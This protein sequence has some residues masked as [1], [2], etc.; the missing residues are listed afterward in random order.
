MRVWCVKCRLFNVV[1]GPHREMAVDVPESFIARNKTPPRYP[2][3]RPPQVGGPP[4]PHKPTK[5][6]A[7]PTPAK[8]TL[9]RQTALDDEEGELKPHKPAKTFEPKPHED[10]DS[11]MDVEVLITDGDMIKVKD[12]LNFSNSGP[13]SGSGSSSSFG[14]KKSSRGSGSQGTSNATQSIRSVSSSAKDKSVLS[15]D[16]PIS[17]GKSSVAYDVNED[18]MVKLYIS[19]DK[20]PFS[21][22]LFGESVA[23][24]ALNESVMI[25]IVPGYPKGED[26]PLPA[27]SPLSSS[28]QRAP[29]GLQVD[30]GCRYGHREMAVDVPD[31]FVQIVKSTPKYPGSE[32]KPILAPQVT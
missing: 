23:F 2:P 13:T 31:G 22:I 19:D 17:I 18:N 3:P 5:P 30:A 26:S 12:D 20:N 11:K 10:K 29:A 9:I 28:S 25:P 21:K 16:S 15:E 8:L 1:A 14:S 6:S 27:Y 4:T 32:K 7:K 24:S